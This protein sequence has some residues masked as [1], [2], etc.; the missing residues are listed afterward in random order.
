MINQNNQ[1]LRVNLTKLPLNFASLTISDTSLFLLNMLISFYD[2]RIKEY[3]SFL[4]FSRCRS[5]SGEHRV[6]KSHKSRHS[7][8]TPSPSPPSHKRSR[9]VNKTKINYV[10]TQGDRDIFVYKGITVKICRITDSFN[11]ESIL[12]S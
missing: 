9:W 2:L 6:K 8:Y 11:Q 10:A 12:L 7:S 3:T 5:R 1:D 4:C